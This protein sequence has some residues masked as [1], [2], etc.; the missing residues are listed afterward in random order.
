MVASSAARR[1]AGGGASVRRYSGVAGGGGAAFPARAR[2][3]S[4]LL[5]SL[6]ENG[7]C[8]AR[9]SASLRS[10]GL[11]HYWDCVSASIA[12]ATQ[13]CGNADDVDSKRI[14]STFGRAGREDSSPGVEEPVSHPLTPE[15]TPRSDPGVNWP[16]TRHRARRFPVSVDVGPHCVGNPRGHNANARRDR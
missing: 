7:P 3:C 11:W 15:R 1:C 6:L 16:R 10:A 9:W 14:D 4:G 2:R 13:K 5:M 12:P 8:R